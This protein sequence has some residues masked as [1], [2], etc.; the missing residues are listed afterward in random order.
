[1]ARRED[2][3]N[4]QVAAAANPSGFGYHHG[5]IPNPNHGWIP[6]YPAITAAENA[7]APN[8]GNRLSTVYDMV[9]VVTTQQQ[10]RI[11]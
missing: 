1:M 11:C 4:P 8:P 2:Y 6:A 5:A 7:T 10:H 3:D 9:L